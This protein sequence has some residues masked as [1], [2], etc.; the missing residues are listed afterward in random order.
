MSLFLRFIVCSSLAPLIMAGMH[1]YW[2]NQLCEPPIVGVLITLLAGSFVSVFMFVCM[3]IMSRPTL[4]PWIILALSTV[5]LVAS[6]ASARS[7]SSG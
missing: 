5:L 7:R 4:S 6:I 2:G 3:Q 1:F